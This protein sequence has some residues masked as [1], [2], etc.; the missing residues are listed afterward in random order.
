MKL[1]QNL[2][3]PCGLLEPDAW[4]AG[5]SGSEGA[6]AQQCAGATRRY[7]FRGRLARGPSGLF[8]SLSPA[9]STKAKKAI[10]GKVRAWHLNR[11]TG[12]DLSGLAE[13]V[14]PQ[15][16]GWINY[17]VPGGHARSERREVISMT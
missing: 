17:C 3:R 16:R 13:D 7:T 14:N 2:R 8:V 15:V 12:T 11:R 4:K 10:G 9:M 5:T 1:Q 6:P